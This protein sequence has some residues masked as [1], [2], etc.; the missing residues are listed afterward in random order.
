VAA[1]IAAA[2]SSAIGTSPSRSAIRSAS[3]TGRSGARNRSRSVLS[4]RSKT[5]IGTG[6]AT[7]V[8]QRGLRLVMSTWP[9]PL[10]R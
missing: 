6:C 5:P 3:A 7:S 2:R 4:E 1:R 8:G 9:A 10:G